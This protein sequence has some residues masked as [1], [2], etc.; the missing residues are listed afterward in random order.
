MVGR[1]VELCEN[2]RSNYMRTLLSPTLTF[3]E[4]SDIAETNPNPNLIFDPYISP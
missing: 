3:K 4:E 2:K 1:D